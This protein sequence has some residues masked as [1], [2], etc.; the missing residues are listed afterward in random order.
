MGF[1]R[2]DDKIPLTVIVTTKNEEKKIG[3]CLASL[4]AFAKVIVVDSHSIDRTCPIAREHGVQV[5]SFRWDGKYPKK[6]QWCLETLALSYDW[7]FWVDADEVVTPALVKEIREIFA[8]KP[9]H[10]GYFVRG[11]YVWNGE[12]LE[13][14]MMNNKL[15]LF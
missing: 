1:A 4:S 10:A 5:V 13:H 7:V 6:R 9:A 14:G 2:M 11:R 8:K 3:R 12:I 15:C